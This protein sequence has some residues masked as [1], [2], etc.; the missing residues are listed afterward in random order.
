MHMCTINGRYNMKEVLTTITKRGQVTIPAEVR[1]LLG[2]KPRDK[3]VFEIEDDQVRLA[4]AK[5][6]LETAYGSIKP[7]KRPEDFEEV[8]RKAK[9]EHVKKAISE[10]HQA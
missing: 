5:F 2:V 8:A 6:T 3:V 7:T 9:E 10:L 4:P 1:R